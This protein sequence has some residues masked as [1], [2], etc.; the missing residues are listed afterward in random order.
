MN[1]LLERA[2]LEYR[3]SSV[4]EPLSDLYQ[5]SVELQFPSNPSHNEAA[6][7]WRALEAC[8]RMKLLG[9]AGLHESSPDFETAFGHI[10]ME[11]W[12]EHRASGD[13]QDKQ[14]REWFAKFMKKAVA[15]YRN[16]EKPHG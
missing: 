15:A 3:V 5:I 6:E 16:K 4:S 13:S 2:G 11:F 12:T 7:K 14:G 9:C 8:A 1:K 10:G